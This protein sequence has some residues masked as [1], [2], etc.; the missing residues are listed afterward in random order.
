MTVRRAVVTAVLLGMLLPALV[1][2]FYLARVSYADKLRSEVALTLQHDADVIALGVRES[3]WALDSESA[4]ALVEA[5]MK[6]SALVTVE[7]LDP[8]LGRFVFR[9]FP[10]RRE[11]VV[12]VLERQVMHRGETIGRVRIELSEAPLRSALLNQILGF[13]SLLALQVIISVI[14]ILV[15]LQRRVGRPLLRLGEE[16]VSLARGEL[17]KPIIPSRRDEIGDVEAQLEVTRQA[18]QGLFHTLEQKNRALEVDLRERMRVEAALRDREQ[19]LRTLVEQSPLAVIEFDLGWHILDWNEAAVRIFGWRREEVLGRHAGMLVANS[20]DARDNLSVNQ[21]LERSVASP[22]IKLACKRSD[23]AGVTCQWYNSLIRDS[24]GTGQRIV[25]MVEDIT[26]RQ[27]SDDEIRR[28]ATVVRL[29]SNLVALTDA[30]GRIEW[31]NHA[32]AERCSGHASEVRGQALVDVLQ[33]QELTGETSRAS[34]IE[35]AMNN[36]RHLTELEMPCRGQDGQS[37]WVSLE[38]QPLRDDNEQIIQWVALMTDVTERRHTTDALRAIARLGGELSPGM[39]LEQLLGVIARGCGAQAAYLATHTRDGVDISASLC[40]PGWSLVGGHHPGRTTLAAYAERTGALL[41]NTGAYEAISRDAVSWGCSLTQALILEPVV[42]S[43]QQVSGHLALL[44]DSPL[45]ATEAAQSLAALGA[46]RA[47]TEFQRLLTLEALRHSEQKFSSIFQYSPIPI[48]VLRRSDSVCLDVNP[49]FLQNFGYPRNEVVG[50]PVLATPIYTDQ[51]EREWVL[52]LL[53]EAGEVSGADMRLR[54]CDGEIRDCQIYVRQISMDE[55]PCLLVATVD[56]TSLLEAQRQ[57]EELNQSLEKRVTERTHDLATTNAELEKTLE[58]LKRTLDELVRSEKLAALGSLVAGI[59]HELNTPIGNSLMVASTLHDVN[60][61]FREQ[62]EAGLRRSTLD[63]YVA[64]SESAADILLRN[65]QRAAEL[66][67]SFKQVAVDQTS[68]QRRRFELAEVV[69]EIVVTMQPVF[70]KTSHS[71]ETE[72]PAGISLD[73]Y[74]GPLG[75]VIANLLNNT[76]LHAFEGQERG[77]VRLRAELDGA[78]GVI[79][80]CQDDGIGIHAN[81]LRRIFD[82]FFTTKLGRDGTGLGLNIVHNIVTGIL[83]GE[84]TVDSSPGQGS[85]FRI[86]IPLKAPAQEDTLVPPKASAA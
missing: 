56:V 80:T 73:S 27:R 6:E 60:Q 18:L 52:Q 55:E 72:I 51:R 23:A 43:Q 30:S 32:F 86:C 44:F 84:I 11:G 53:N 71:I 54:T 9:E 70:R 83:G 2:G 24:A 61:S 7:I 74:P 79:F 5:V 1:V 82:P 31:I 46:A 66:I 38:L 34:A 49:S 3:L 29:T 62:M 67:S 64:E 28:L 14:L 36:G 19:R 41:L 25:A 47:S 13:A 8:H 35:A 85:C 58:R 63:N 17:D 57:V 76:I 68:S 21:L 75:Q 33:A 81:N 50:Q 10:E 15:V 78:G 39:F 77:T 4:A 16:A 26:E 22:H 48:G 12:H 69:S 20:K 42:D 40:A 45:V 59:A 65:L 37:F